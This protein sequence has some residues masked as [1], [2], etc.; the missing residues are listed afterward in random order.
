ME[1]RDGGPRIKITITLM[2]ML[3]RHENEGF[4]VKKLHG[5]CLASFVSFLVSFLQN[6]SCTFRV[7]VIR[8]EHA[9]VGEI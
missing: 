7:V 1:R 2:F 9:K 4:V 6:T 8:E 3:S 5:N